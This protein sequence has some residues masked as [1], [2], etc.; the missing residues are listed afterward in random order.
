MLRYACA[1]LSMTILDQ[2]FCGVLIKEE[3][4]Q[5]LQGLALLRQYMENKT[6]GTEKEE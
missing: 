2:L 4:E 1:A 5:M 3:R 6:E